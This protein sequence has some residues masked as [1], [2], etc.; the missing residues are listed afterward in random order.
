MNVCEVF[1]RRHTTNKET[2][3]EKITGAPE[4]QQWVSA[5]V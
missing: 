5:L 1:G 4:N 3:Y 2:Y